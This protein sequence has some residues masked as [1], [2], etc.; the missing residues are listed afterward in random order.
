M[1]KL[2]E[3]NLKAL[4]PLPEGF[5]ERVHTRLDRMKASPGKPVKRRPTAIVLVFAALLILSTGV[6]AL[7]Q[8]G[9]LDFLFPGIQ[10]DSRGAVQALTHPVQI[11][12]TVDNM[13]LTIDSLFYDGESFALDWTLK[14]ET[15]DH[16]RFV[17]LSRFTVNGQKLWSDGNDGFDGQWLPGYFSKDGTMQDGEYHLLSHESLGTSADKLDVHFDIDIYTP[18]KPLYYLPENCAEG[19]TEEEQQ[20]NWAA[21]HD[22]IQ[23]KLDTGYIVMYNDEFVIPD[24]AH[25]GEFIRVIGKLANIMPQGDY[26]CRT[27]ETAFSVDVSAFRSAYKKLSPEP[28]Y[29][30]RAFTL[31]YAK[32]VLTPAGL[33]LMADIQLGRDV[34]MD[35]LNEGQWQVSDGMGRKIDIFPL[36]GEVGR[37]A[38]NASYR[39]Y[40][41]LPL[42]NSNVRLPKSV[43]LSF[44]PPFGRPPLISAI[45]I[46]E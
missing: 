29:A 19:D 12:K 17:E 23:E 3:S 34:S 38:E 41:V 10:E 36:V 7:N 25:S 42:V 2:N 14:N 28:E 22:L 13:K 39:A 32:A 46:P 1:T 30:Y 31:T 35:Y 15:P 8:Y 26:I 44:Y 20:K 27:M 9:V 16:P 40:F 5:T 18:T 37:P 21:Q 45:N 6:L 33:Y 24:P 11:E 43:S 4:Y